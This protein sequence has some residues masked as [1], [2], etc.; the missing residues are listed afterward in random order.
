M[1]DERHEPVPIR[2]FA[3]TWL[4]LL[5]LTATTVVVSRIPLG[6]LNIVAALGIATAKSGLVILIFMHL[7]HENRIFKFFFFVALLVLAI[8]VGMTFFDVLYR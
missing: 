1:T 6:P 2:T 7:R 8:F 3:V 5:A 4:V